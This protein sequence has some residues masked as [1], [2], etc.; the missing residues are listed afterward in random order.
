MDRCNAYQPERKRTKLTISKWTGLIR[1][2]TL[3]D[4]ICGLHIASYVESPYKDRGGL[5]LVGPAG[6]LKTTLLD[7]LDNNYHNALAISNSHMSTMRKLQPAFYN[8]QVRSLCF[9]DLQSIYAG[10]PRTANRIEQMMMQLSGEATR[11]IGGDEDSRYAKFKGYCTMF[12]AMT[13]SFY[14]AHINK[15]DEAGFSRRF[16]WGTYTFQDPDILMRAVAQWTRATLGEN[17]VPVCPTNNLIPDSLKQ[18][19]REE[20][21]TWL[22]HQPQPHEI[23][24]QV[25][26][27]ATSALAWHYKQNR[28]R[29]NAMEVM[30]EFSEI[31]QHD[32]ALLQLPDQTY[33][34]V[35]SKK[36]PQ[37]R[38]RTPPRH[39]RPARH[40]K[41]VLRS[42]PANNRHQH[43]DIP[44]QT[45]PVDEQ[46]TVGD[47]HQVPEKPDQTTSLPSRKV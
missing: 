17:V 43:H 35:P 30:R 26:C 32:A 15:W 19:D 9:P 21:Q 42:P 1:V 45:S 29:K 38:K 37:T 20:I 33:D 39:L 40:R 18:A 12:A 16:L 11:T 23:Q 25:M 41:T 6:V 31:L 7:V 2:E 46:R 36:L 22:R 47:L 27:K 10:D 4:G 44:V 14:T 28:I 3:V 13:P 5:M 34:Q 8:G 24:F